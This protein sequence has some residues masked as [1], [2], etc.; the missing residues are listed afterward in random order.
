MSF[1]R[2]RII[3]YSI[4]LIWLLFGLLGKLIPITPTHIQIVARV[5][6]DPLSR[7]ITILIG[8]GELLIAL[9]VISGKWRTVCGW[10]QIALVVIMN[11]IEL[12]IA[13]DLLLWGPLNGF[14]ALIF[15][16]AVYLHMVAPHRAS[17]NNK[18]EYKV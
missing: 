7:P 1:T 9:W 2:S 10:L 16:V 6:G 13:R 11:C 18:A 15:V 8:V 17:G 12:T 4:A 14:F 5:F 3:T